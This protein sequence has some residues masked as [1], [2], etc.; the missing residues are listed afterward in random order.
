[1]LIHPFKDI[2]WGEGDGGSSTLSLK[3]VFKVM[4]EKCLILL[5][6]KTKEI[7]FVNVNVWTT[8]INGGVDILHWKLPQAPCS[9]L[10][11]VAAITQSYRR[12]KSQGPQASIQEGGTDLRKHNG[13]FREIMTFIITLVNPS[14]SLKWSVHLGPKMWESLGSR[15]SLGTMVASPVVLSGMCGVQGIETILLHS[16]FPGWHSLID[17]IQTLCLFKTADSMWWRESSYCLTKRKFEKSVIVKI[18]LSSQKQWILRR[19]E[20]TVNINI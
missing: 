17:P 18:V 14:S 20:I 5:R 3:I 8:S 16:I 1:M 4:V 11:S 2:S 6:G 13:F 19:K 10:S 15:W 9:L 7:S 12:H